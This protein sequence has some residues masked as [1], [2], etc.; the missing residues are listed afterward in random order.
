GQVVVLDGSRA[1]TLDGI[2]RVGY[3]GTVL[4]LTASD[5]SHASITTRDIDRGP[6]PHYLLKELTDAPPSLRQTLRGRH[7]DRDGDLVRARG[8]TVVAIVNR[9]NSDLVEKSDGVIYTS[10]GRDVEMSVPSTKAF[11]AQ[12]AAGALFA[13][14][15]APDAGADPAWVSELLAGLQRLP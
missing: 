7:R 4:P 10:D 8:A 6:F 1:G 15:L 13:L 11:Y 2:R 14:R 5:L 9:R 3:D 12:V